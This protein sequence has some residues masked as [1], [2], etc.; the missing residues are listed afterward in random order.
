MKTVV[1]DHKKELVKLIDSLRYKYGVYDIFRDFCEMAAITV[2]NACA[3]NDWQEREDRYMQ[4]VG[5]YDEKEAA[6]FPEMF[7]HLVL[8]LE[9]SGPC[10]ILG[11]VFMALEI[12]NKDAGQFFTPQ[13]VCD[14]IG[15]IQAPDMKELVEKH[16]FI[17]LQEPAVG[18]GAMVFG[19]CKAMAKQGLDFTTQLHVTAIDVDSRCKDM[20]YVQMSL[21]GIPGIVWLGDTLR[22]QMR[23]AWVTPL[24]VIGGWEY[25]LSLRRQKEQIDAALAGPVRTESEPIA[26]E[27]AP[28]ISIGKQGQL[29]LTL[30]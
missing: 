10:D 8:A 3:K 1:T 21:L 9:E 17:T 5:K 12:S 26:V 20:C 30:V 22:M 11:Q 13:S 6:V 18:G 4:V 7:A 19:L 23:S 24:H 15:D 27:P 16:G 25:K 2:S 14:M 29:E 28:V